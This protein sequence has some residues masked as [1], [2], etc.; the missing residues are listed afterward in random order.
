[1]ANTY[2][3]IVADAADNVC[4]AKY[5]MWSH[6]ASHDKQFSPH[7]KIVCNVEQFVMWS[8]GNCSIS[9]ACGA[10]GDCSTWHIYNVCCLVVINAVLTQNQFCRDW[11]GA[12][13]N[14]KSCPC[15]KNDKYDVW[16]QL[17]IE[18]TEYIDDQK[19]P[20]VHPSFSLLKTVEEQ[21]KLLKFLFQPCM[22]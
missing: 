19:Q 4:G 3:I 17:E 18:W 10:I 14:Q 22:E 13:I 15:S 7:D 12:K 6:L 1:M 16:L 5:F 11:C 21:I 8:F 20:S 9:A 2:M